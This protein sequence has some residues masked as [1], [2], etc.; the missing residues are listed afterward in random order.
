MNTPKTY[1]LFCEYCN[2]RKITDGTNINLVEYKTADI[3]VK[4]PNIDSES[5]KMTEGTFRAL[6]KRF[7]CPQCG[8][9]I[10]P[11]IVENLQAK[12]DE[13]NRLKDR[14]AR[15]AEYEKEQERKEKEKYENRFNGDQT[16]PE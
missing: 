2:Y 9:L 6:P 10:R 4:I 13:D 15:R 16:S 1:Q 5:G 11:K 8:R 12:I 14:I 3:Q 7:K